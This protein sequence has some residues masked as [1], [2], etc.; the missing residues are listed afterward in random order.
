ME[1][2]GEAWIIILQN[3]NIYIL[4]DLSEISIYAKDQSHQDN[5]DA[6]SSPDPIQ[7]LVLV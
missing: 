4:V 2:P 1:L 6:I 5:L 7:S 3:V